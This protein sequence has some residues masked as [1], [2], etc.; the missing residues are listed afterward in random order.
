MLRVCRGDDRADVTVSLP[1]ETGACEPAR[2]PRYL[3]A[4]DAVLDR[5]RAGPLHVLY[6]ASAGHGSDADLEA[7]LDALR[8]AG[9][10]CTRVP[11]E[12]PSQLDAVARAAARRVRE[13]GGALVAVG[14]DGT[15]N[16]V[17]HAAMAE[18]VVV[19]LMPRGTFNY[20]GRE[21]GLPAEPAAAARVL[22]CGKPY[23]VQAGRVNG[24]LFLVNAGIGFYARL[25]E[26]RETWKPRLGRRRIVA[27][28]AGLV[29]CL[30]GQRPL[31]LQLDE[32]GEHRDLRTYTLF[33]GNNRLQL[34]QVG[35]DEAWGIGCGTLAG[36]ALRPVGRLPLLWALIG[37]ARGRLGETRS[38]ETFAFARATVGM[39][40]RRRRVKLWTDGEVSRTTLPLEFRVAEAPLWLLCD[41]DARQ[42]TP[43]AAVT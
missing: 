13:Q 10:A 16:A 24:R 35:V 20:F 29:S 42:V 36:V 11:V 3:P 30:R 40:R 7:L 43:G 2:P 8:L 26:D 5:L 18:G 41:P 38:V 32:Q 12:H 21:H 31:T 1:P 25:L 28:L 39:K 19:G 17:A 14:G 33:V 23:G 34:E 37:G 15:F 4:P 22:T 27:F 9:R 6:N